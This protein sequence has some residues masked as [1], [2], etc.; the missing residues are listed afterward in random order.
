MSKNKPK[1]HYN[2]QFCEEIAL[3][4]QIV[5]MRPHGEGIL[6]SVPIIIVV[7]ERAASRFTMLNHGAKVLFRSVYTHW[8]SYDQLQELWVAALSPVHNGVETWFSQ[9]PDGATFYASIVKRAEVLCN[10]ESYV[11]PAL[12][13]K[14]EVL[15]N[16]GETWEVSAAEGNGDEFVGPFLNLTIKKSEDLATKVAKLKAAC[17]KL[18]YYAEDMYFPYVVTATASDSSRS[19]TKQFATKAEA[20][21]EVLLL[22][23]AA[24]LCRY[25]DIYNRGYQTF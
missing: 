18:D 19:W 25:T 16:E 14:V 17:K 22:S 15:G 10:M 7:G 20:L 6:L 24:P 12:D 2:V 23:N 21:Q 9:F 8:F 4:D 3:A 11:L 13:Q 1:L 5:T